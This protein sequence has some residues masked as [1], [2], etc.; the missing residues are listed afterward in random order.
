[1]RYNY[2]QEKKVNPN[3]E[4]VVYGV[5]ISDKEAVKKKVREMRIVKA[6]LTLLSLI[7]LAGIGFI[8]F[9]FWNVSFN[10]GRP[11]VALLSKVDSGIKFQGIG[12]S[13]IRCSDGKVHLNE[14]DDI[15]NP[16]DD[17]VTTFDEMLHKVL[18]TYL[19]ENKIIDNNF[20]DLT[21]NSYSRDSE[22]SQGGYDYYVDLTYSCNDGS[23]TCF[24]PFK[25][26]SDKKNIQIYVSLDKTNTV[27]DVFNFKKSGT[28]YEELNEEYKEKVKD[29][30]IKNNLYVEENV[31]YLNVKLL[32]NK[33]TN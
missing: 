6:I 5:N 19:N 27:F 17:G 1:M 30:L 10:G 11:I 22:N 20:K 25:D 15:C 2:K 13:Y 21:I 33:K 14:E 8:V 4:N 29:Y 31:R 32:S 12:Y 24:K 9:D 26:K 3:N 23:D 18:I 16:K 28:H 7:I